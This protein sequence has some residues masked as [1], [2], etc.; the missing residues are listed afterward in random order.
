MKHLW[1]QLQKVV[2]R[3]VDIRADYAGN[4]DEFYNNQIIRDSNY[5]VWSLKDFMFVMHEHV[6]LYN[7][8]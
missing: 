7:G 4:C 2:A 5:I 1:C 6:L 3:A 8:S